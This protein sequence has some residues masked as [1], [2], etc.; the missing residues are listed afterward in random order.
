MYTKSLPAYRFTCL[1]VHHLL[2]LHYLPRAHVICIC[3]F[4]H[5]RNCIPPHHI[6]VSLGINFWLLVLVRTVR[7]GP[8]GWAMVCLGTSVFVCGDLCVLGTSGSP[9]VHRWAVH[10]MVAP[11]IMSRTQVSHSRM[12]PMPPNRL[13]A[14]SFMYLVRVEYVVSSVDH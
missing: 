3:Y 12:Y 13:R 6:I 11:W 5:L 2:L 8:R 1:P 4:G 7:V 14:L 10:P 9:E